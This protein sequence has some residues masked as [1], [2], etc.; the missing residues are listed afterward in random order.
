MPAPA[1]AGPRHLPAVQDGGTIR[2]HPPH[3][4]RRDSV[5]PFG[6]GMPLSDVSKSL[7]EGPH[8]EILQLPRLANWRVVRAEGGRLVIG[9][10]ARN[11]VS[12]I[13]VLSADVARTSSGIGVGATVAE[14]TEALGPLRPDRTL[15]RD[16]AV[17][18]VESLPGVR[19]V[20]NAFDDV[21]APDARV[22]GVV[23]GN[24]WRP[25]STAPRRRPGAGAHRQLRGSDEGRGDGRGGRA[26]PLR[27]SSTVNLEAMVS[28]RDVIVGGE[29]DALHRL[30]T[31]E[32]PEVAAF[33]V[34]MTSTTTVARSCCSSATVEGLDDAV[35][36]RLC[37]G[38]AAS[39]WRSTRRRTC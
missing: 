13:S 26:G 28:G 15:V 3:A 5:G 2:A 39:P 29:A 20:T 31:L 19:F 7:P 10:D 37:S 9:A 21:P 33:A 14:L 23:V 12:Y 22:I 34:V 1:D 18:E 8:V 25:H 16:R 27:L 11:Q 36:L 35:D 24:G 17:V 32:L 30:G 38:T 6:L 4:I